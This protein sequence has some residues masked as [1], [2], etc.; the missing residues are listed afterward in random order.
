MEL[1]EL[2]PTAPVLATL[3]TELPPELITD[4]TDEPPDLTV[5]AMPVAT[6]PAPDVIVVTTPVAIMISRRFVLWLK[7]KFD[8]THQLIRLRK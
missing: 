7:T 2:V 6:D 3:A 4:T 8:A 5:V 1:L